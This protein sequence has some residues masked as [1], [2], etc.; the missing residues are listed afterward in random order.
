MCETPVPLICILGPTAAGKTR[1]AAHVAAIVNGEVISADSRQ[2]YRRMD[3]GTG[4]DLEDYLIRGQTV[5]S[6]LI[7][8]VDPGYEYNVYE[9]KRDCVAAIREIHSRHR[10]P[11]LC[12]G[13][14]LYLSAILEDYQLLSAPPDPTRRV[15]LEATPTDRLIAVLQSHGPLHNTSDI[16]DRGR[17]I[18]AIEIADADPAARAPSIALDSLVFGL[19]WERRELRQRITRRLEYRLEHGLLDEVRA[20]LDQGLTHD[21]LIFYGLE[22]RYVT[23][24]V[25]GDITQGEMF[26]ALNTAIHKFAKRQETWFRRMERQGREIH[27]LDGRDSPEINATTVTNLLRSRQSSRHRPDGGAEARP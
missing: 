9:F 15:E 17:L 6:H 16:E 26:D 5:R 23:E 18:R 10:L 8:I 20:L 24:H 22:Y 2:I 4:K 25:R 13:T 7:D 3:V 27:W 1:L 12:G 21:Q 14:G 19:R 11:V